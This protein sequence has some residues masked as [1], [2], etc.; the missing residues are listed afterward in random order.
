MKST[1]KILIFLPAILS[2][3]IG[4]LA[5][6]FSHRCYKFLKKDSQF[7]TSSLRQESQK[8]KRV[9]DIIER[10][11]LDLYLVMRDTAVD[12]ARHII[13]TQEPINEKAEEAIKARIEGFKDVYFLEISQILDTAG[14]AGAR[15]KKIE[16]ELKAVISDLVLDS[17]EIERHVL[18]ENIKERIV[19]L[20]NNSFKYPKDTI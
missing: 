13:N 2:E 18:E 7:N 11:F 4:M 16:P 8:L 10:F 20:I 1:V 3:V 5:I 14:L 19:D 17:L 9:V 15:I 6:M 12:T